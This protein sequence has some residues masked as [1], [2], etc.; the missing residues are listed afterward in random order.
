MRAFTKDFLRPLYVIRAKWLQ[1]SI[2]DERSG[3]V[4]Y[5]SPTPPCRAEDVADTVTTRDCPK[6]GKVW[7]GAVMLLIY[8]AKFLR[9]PP[10]A[11]ARARN[12]FSL[13]CRYYRLHNI[14]EAPKRTDSV[15]TL[16]VQFIATTPSFTPSAFL[17]DC[18]YALS[19]LFSLDYLIRLYSSLFQL[20]LS[21]SARSFLASRQIG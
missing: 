11:R 16:N 19:V 8:K 12:I 18:F 5:R 6:K 21:L 9:C 20:S 7:H 1:D 15:L 2:E 14:F 13:H 17:D 10:C 4:L 3:I